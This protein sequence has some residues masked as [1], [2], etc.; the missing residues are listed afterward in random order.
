MCSQM[1]SLIY[2]SCTMRFLTANIFNCPVRTEWSLIVTDLS[3][4]IIQCLVKEL[5]YLTNLICCINVLLLFRNIV[6]WVCD[7]T[8][9]LF[10]KI[11]EGALA[12]KP[13]P[14][15][16][17]QFSNYTYGPLLQVSSFWF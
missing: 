5:K 7:S 15:E 17:S 1:T 6:S 13:F 12:R 3:S 2:V 14:F 4:T 16:R 10:N 8:Q 9:S 11:S